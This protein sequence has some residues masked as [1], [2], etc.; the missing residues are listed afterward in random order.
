MVDNYTTDK[1]WCTRRVLKKIF[2]LAFN[3]LQVE[4]ISILV[5]TTNLPCIRLVERLGF[6]Q[7]GLL[8]KYRD[9]GSS[10]FFYGILKSENKW[11]K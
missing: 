3:F 10:C 2:G 1:R 11:S 9:D 8:R 7:E 4:R 5:S 6:K